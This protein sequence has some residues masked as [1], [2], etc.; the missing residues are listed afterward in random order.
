MKSMQSIVGQSRQQRIYTLLSY[1][2]MLLILATDSLTELS[3]SHGILYAPVLL[4][5]ALTGRLPVLNVVFALSIL[6]VWLG[7]YWATISNDDPAS[8][9]HYANRGLVSLSLLVIYGLLRR[10]LRHQKT[11][12]LQNAQLQIS[13]KLAKLGS[14]RLDN[15]QLVLSAEAAQIL[16]IN[17]QPLSLKHF[18]K[19]LV[20][21][22]GRHLLQNLQAEK[23]PLDAEYRRRQNNGEIKWLRLVAY[24]DDQHHGQIHGVLQDIHSSRV[25]E[26]QIAEEERRF[27]Y[28][29]D[30]IQFFAWTA[31]P[32]GNLDYVS[33]FTVD[34]FGA[35][36]RFIT[37]NWLSFLHPDDQQPTMNRW[38]QSLKTGEPYVVE[39]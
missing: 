37:E 10:S 5:A 21:T 28:M 17:Q 24:Q 15:G 34:F 8:L 14:W 33:R 9:N 19:I 12:Q 7:F 35:S 11:Q 29:A 27:R 20:D 3:F 23:L 13:A 38:L 39:F 31:L 18:A 36:E 30:S 32:D 16:E 25:V 6:F 4:L 26:A 22:D 2:L 1:G